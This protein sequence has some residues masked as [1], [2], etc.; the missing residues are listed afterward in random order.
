SL[1]SLYAFS[2]QV[3]VLWDYIKGFFGGE[4]IPT[5]VLGH[6]LAEAGRIGREAGQRYIDGFEE[7]ARARAGQRVEERTNPTIYG[8]NA[9]DP[10]D[11]NAEETLLTRADILER[12]DR[13]LDQNLQLT[14]L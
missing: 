8:Y 14:R 3:L 2:H 6:R 11:V 9:V 1:R 13:E 7:R 5:E 12:F 10:R 4:D